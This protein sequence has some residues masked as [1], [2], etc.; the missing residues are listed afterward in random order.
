V[1]DVPFTFKE[2]DKAIGELTGTQPLSIPFAVAARSRGAGAKTLTSDS[3][4][5]ASKTRT[6]FDWAPASRSPAEGVRFG[7]YATPFS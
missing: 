5:S 6:T 1:G 7:P 2:L 4:F 3:S